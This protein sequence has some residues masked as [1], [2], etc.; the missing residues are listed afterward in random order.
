MRGLVDSRARLGQTAMAVLLL[1]SPVARAAPTADDVK[2]AA[3]AFDLG[4]AAYKKQNWVEAAEQFEA[5]DS[6]APS[7]AALELALRS[8]DKAGQIDRAAI[9]AELGLERHSGEPALKKL[10]TSVIARAKKE[11][12]TLH[13]S[14]RPACD[15]VLGTI[16]VHGEASTART[17]YLVPG[18]VQV[19][20]SW[21]GRRARVAPIQA[22]AGGSSE[23]AFTPPEPAPEPRDEQQK[24]EG[25]APTPAVVKVT[26]ARDPGADAGGG[27]PPVVFFV[28]A[29]LT[30][31]AAGV[32]VWSGIDTQNNPGADT[33]RTECAGQGT[34]CP[35]Y[36]DGLDR[37]QRT[38]ILLGVTAGLAVTTGVI[39]ALL[40][41]W[42]GKPAQSA[43][44]EPWLGVGSVGARGRF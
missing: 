19:S 40:T 42:S 9:L 35:A 3:A 37:Q 16:L 31:V 4:K 33:V 6:R 38:N 1:S 10:A 44:L 12:Y 5:A 15:L 34:S 23:S 20:A 17:V 21:S 32:T 2:A 30:A 24:S 18:E 11:L 8:R 39:G 29:G 27:L 13:V 7:A 36:Q 26:P 14:C 22:V 43:R 41:D 28:G 25:P